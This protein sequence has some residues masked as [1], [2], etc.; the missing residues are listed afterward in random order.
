M[1]VYASTAETAQLVQSA[2]MG[3]I[4]AFAM[5]VERYEHE[6]Y[7]YLVGMLGDCE[8]AQDLSQQVF[9]KA[10]IN[11]PALQNAASF[12]AWLYSIA[13]HLMC[14]HWRGKKPSSQSWEELLEGNAEPGLPGP[15]ECI[16]E[17]E[18]INMALL[19]LPLKL[20]QCLVLRFVEGFY[21]CEIACM[22]GISVTSVSTYISM[23]RRQFRAIFER[24]KD[25]LENEE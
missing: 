21:P 15:E 16:V 3:S 18:L 25:E 10:W 23:A 11:L 22:V 20:R 14:D 24:L 7:R 12:K 4:E 19:E 1:L 6:I 2:Q 5:L 9:L 8:E 13:R 17:M